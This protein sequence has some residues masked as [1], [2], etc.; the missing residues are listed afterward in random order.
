MERQM[1][2]VKVKLILEEFFK[3]FPRHTVNIGFYE[4]TTVQCSLNFVTNFK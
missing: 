4:D 3:R 2:W 1:F